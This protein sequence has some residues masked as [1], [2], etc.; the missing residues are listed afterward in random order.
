MTTDRKF[1]QALAWAQMLDDPEP[2]WGPQFHETYLGFPSVTTT[3]LNQL[4]DF[5]N[6]YWTVRESDRRVGWM[7]GEI[8][9]SRIKRATQ[10][11]T[12][13][14]CTVMCP[15]CGYDTAEP[16]EMDGTDMFEC[17]ACHSEWYQERKHV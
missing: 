3:E 11:H 5:L 15:E 10:E 4:C 17:L 6:A 13:T 12:P 8:M 7:G 2:I 1:A 16:F 9:P 14:S